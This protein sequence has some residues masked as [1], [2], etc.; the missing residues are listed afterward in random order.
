MNVGKITDARD[1]VL[2]TFFSFRL[3]ISSIRPSSRGATNGPFLTERDM[4]SSLLLLADP[5]SDDQAARGLGATGP[6]AHRRLAPRR[7]GRHPRRRLAFA[8]AVRMVSRVHHHAADLGP[9]AQMP[10]PARL[11]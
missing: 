3:F 2:T 7:L 4:S 11:A 9:L 6:I 8:S 1:H 5:R 10:S